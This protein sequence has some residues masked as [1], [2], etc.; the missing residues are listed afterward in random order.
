MRYRNTLAVAL[1]AAITI[2]ATA[3]AAIGLH[4]ASQHF[5]EKSYNND[6][7][8]VYARFDNGLTIGTYRNSFRRQATYAAYTY[9]YGRFAVSAGLISGYDRPWLLVPSV[10]VLD[11]DNVSLRLA[12][13]PAIEK[14]GSSVAHLMLEAKF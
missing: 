9:E 11:I 12:V 2:S 14:G 8:G 5:P 10:R 4:I 7:P 3:D 13:I 6:N 1:L